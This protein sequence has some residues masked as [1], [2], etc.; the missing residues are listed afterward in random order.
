LRQSTASLTRP[1]PPT[2][3]SQLNW[4]QGTRWPAISPPPPSSVHPSTSVTLILPGNAALMRTPTDC[5]D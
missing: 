4:D 1:E 5:S 2:P 3:T